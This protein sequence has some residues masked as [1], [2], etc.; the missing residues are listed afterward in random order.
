[1]TSSRRFL[2]TAEAARQIHEY[3]SDLDDEQRNHANDVCFVMIGSL[4]CLLQMILLK[5]VTYY[6]KLYISV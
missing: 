6:N 5:Y 1:M 4:V 2:T 3:A